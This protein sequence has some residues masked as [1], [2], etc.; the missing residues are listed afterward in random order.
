MFLLSSLVMEQAGCGVFYVH[1]NFAQLTKVMLVF[2]VPLTPTQ[3]YGLDTL[4]ALYRS[5][6]WVYRLVLF[7]FFWLLFLF[8]FFLYTCFPCFGSIPGYSVTLV[9]HG[10]KKS[11]E[12]EM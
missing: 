3:A 4:L 9:D 8:F 6:N 10:S 11:A 5:E 2:Y 1:N 12:C 7:W